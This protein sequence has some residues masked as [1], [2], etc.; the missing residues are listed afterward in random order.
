M[1]RRIE[2]RTRGEFLVERVIERI[3]W[4]AAAG[5]ALA[6]MV[7]VLLCSLQ[8]LDRVAPQRATDVAPVAP[9]QVARP[10]ADTGDRETEIA[11]VNRPSG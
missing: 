3:V 10:L 6:V 1:Q 5:A 7:L 11:A 2:T 9:T 8:W 4:N